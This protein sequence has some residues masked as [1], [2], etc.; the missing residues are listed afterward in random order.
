MKSFMKGR[1]G[2]DALFIGMAVLAGLWRLLGIP[3]SRLRFIDSSAFNAI[4]IFILILAFGRVFSTQLAKRSMENIRFKKFMAPAARKVRL[5][6]N[7]WKDRR[8]HSFVKCDCKKVLRVPKVK[9]VHTVKCPACGRSFE[10]K[11]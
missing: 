4:S 6:R 2:F 8:T 1:Y 9:G 3:M 11:I 7:M 10:V 5:L